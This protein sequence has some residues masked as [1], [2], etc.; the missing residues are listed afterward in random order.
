VLTARH[1]SYLKLL[2]TVAI[3][4]I[5]PPIIKYT[6]RYFP[7]DLFLTY[8][9]FLS[10][11]LMLPILFLIEKDWFHKLAHLPSGAWIALIINSIL[12]STIQIGFL[13]WGLEYT[14]AL[15]GSIIN[16]LSPILV[17]ISGYFFLHEKIT[18]KEKFGLATAFIGSLIIVIAPLLLN[19]NHSLKYS[20]IGNLLIFAGT[21][22]WAIYTV[23]SKKHLRLH[24]S[25]LFLTTAMFFFG[26]ISMTF[27]TVTRH[28]SYFIFQSIK[29]APVS[30]H[31]GVLYMAILSG[32]LAYFLYQSATKYIEIS[33]ANLFLYLAP[34]FTLP[35]SLLVLKENL[36]LGTIIGCFIILIGV[37][38]AEI[39]R[40]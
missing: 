27:I 34:I 2:I 7:A 24:L 21:L 19:Q 18:N 32:S 15:E 13:F 25:P 1:S 4:G 10:A 8:R 33:E 26:F 29:V 30:A 20:V 16:A 17:A 3:W 38:L 5:A 28:N 12:G 14:S 31:L 36:D 22:S 9:F 23:I 39:K 11:I 6:L 37:G 40:R 35:I